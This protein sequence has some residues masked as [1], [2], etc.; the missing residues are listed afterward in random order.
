MGE[1]TSWDKRFIEQAEYVSKWSKDT[2][3]KCGAVIVD[4]ENTELVMGYNGFPRGS[5]DATDT[6]RYDKPLKYFWTEHAERNAVYKAARLGISLKNTKMYC[7]YFPCSDCAR[8]IIQAG[9]CKLYCPKPNFNHHK[10]GE[11]WV[12]A[13][14]MLRECGVAVTWTNNENNENN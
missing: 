5:D 7:T 4:D 8:A 13:I 11:S 6:R 1:L 9:V 10:W 12:E 14:S 3:T 2:N